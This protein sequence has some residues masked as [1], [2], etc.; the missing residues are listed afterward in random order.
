M[1]RIDA[2][3]DGGDLPVKVLQFG[4]GVFLRA[5]VDWMVERMNRAGLFG[6]SVAVVKPRPGDFSPAYESQGNAYTVVLKGLRGGV[7]VDSRERVGAIRRLV[8]PYRDFEAFLAEARNPELVCVVSNTTEAGIAPAPGD[9]AGDR[10]AASFPG[11]LTQ[12]L[13]ARYETFAGAKDKG[14]A[15]IPCELLEDNAALLRDLVLGHALR[16]YADPAFAA[17]LTEANAWT[18]SLVDRIVPGF[19]EEERSR[20]L[21]E[22]GFDDGLLAVA[23]PYHLLALRGSGA[24]EAS[25]PL[26][27][28]GL[29]VVWAEDIAPYRELKVRLLNGGHTLLALCGLALG[30][31]TV[32]ECS[33]DAALMGALRAYQLGETIPTLAPA[34]RGEAP[35]YLESVIE[36]FSNPYLAHRLEGIASNSVSKYAARCLPTARLSVAAGRGAPPLASLVLAALVDRYC[37]GAEVRDE[38]GVKAW[39]ASRAGRFAEDPEGAM[40]DCLGEGGPFGGPPGLGDLAERAAERLAAIRSEGMAG[41]LRAA[42]RDSAERRAPDQAS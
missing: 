35:A 12:F 4:D 25:L 31:S 10:P 15:I 30:R 17:W 29:N 23:E 1:A 22:E 37:S 33:K 7:L 18:D 26:R 40:R 20:L 16:W 34:L 13:R 32:L 6:G 36:R 9:G 5:F 42:V 21:A 28:A 11:K 38:E 2:R 3:A 39:F 41:A 19:S 14:L 8:N 24:L 27:A